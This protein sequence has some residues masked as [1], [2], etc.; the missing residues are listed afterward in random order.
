MCRAHANFI[1]DT[2]LYQIEFN[3][4][5]VTEFIHNVI[6]ESMC[7]QHDAEENK[8][9][10]LYLLIEHWKD[11]RVISLSDQKI[12]VWGR[13]VTDKSTAGWEIGCLLKDGSTSWDK[14][15][16]LKES[17]PVQTAK[18][19]IV[20]GIYQKTAFDWWVKHMLKKRVRIVTGVKKVESQIFTEKP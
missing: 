7:V 8:Y 16:D 2:R 1:L 15:S 17:H 13:Q 10:L 4:G 20:Q 19:P 5:E 3:G 14:L 12:N 18:F 6:T 9:L 11:E